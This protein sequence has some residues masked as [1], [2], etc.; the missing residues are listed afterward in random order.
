MTTLSPL[1]V[2]RQRYLQHIWT[3]A[4]IHMTKLYGYDRYLY[5]LGTMTHMYDIGDEDV[6]P[7]SGSEPQWLNTTTWICDV[8]SV[9]YMYT[10]NTTQTQTQTQNILSLT[11]CNH[12]YKTSSVQLKI[13]KASPYRDISDT[14]LLH[15]TLHVCVGYLLYITVRKWTSFAN[16]WPM[17]IIFHS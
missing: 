14:I 9:L 1:N 16:N 3:C 4:P 2:S 13:T 5:M 10:C 17:S 11:L 8:F 12:I 7:S 15:E 6:P